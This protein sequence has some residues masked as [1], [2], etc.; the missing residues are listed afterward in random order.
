[1]LMKRRLVFLL[2][3]SLSIG[4]CGK[5]GN[6]PPVG[7]YSSVLIVTETGQ[8]DKST[9][10]LVRQ[11]Q[12]P[13]D[14]YTK[15]ELQFKAKLIP[16]SE[17]E[18]EPPSKNMILFGLVR[19]GEIGRLIEG[20]IGTS[21]VRK[22]LEGQINVF[23]KLDYPYAG[24]LT[25]V[26]TAASNE[27][28]AKVVSENGP[29]IRDI[30][31]EAN[32][33]RLRNYL[34]QK[35][36]KELEEEIRAKYKFTLRV[37]FLYELNQERKEV[38]GI[39]F[40]RTAPHRGLTVSWRS[41][42]QGGVSLADSSS[43]YDIRADL[44]WKMYDKDVMRRDLVSFAEDRLGDYRV[45]R[46]DGYWENSEGIYG[47]PYSCFFLYDDLRSRL[48]IVDTLVYGPGFDKHPLLRELR[49]VAE[50]FRPN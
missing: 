27:R 46:M 45:V 8:L 43:L 5:R 9:E 24:Q 38:P 42:Q 12:H 34:L 36:K 15:E 2:L 16:A 7:S 44:A 6:F 32:R 49:A 31:E 40:V 25:I 47:G 50:T 35:E 37:P 22:V 17:L 48:W 41:W 29:L 11:I 23:R 21:S 1:M 18:K 3:I 39:E 26:I 13:V 14:Y 4:S 28:L 30:I 20:F 10:N 19:Q 33:E